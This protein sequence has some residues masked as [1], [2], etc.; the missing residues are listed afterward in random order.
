[1]FL[2]PID[3]NHTKP[4]CHSHTRA[5]MCMPLCLQHVVA[6]VLLLWLFVVSAV[7]NASGL[8]VWLH[9]HPGR[10]RPIPRPSRSE[11]TS[12]NTHTFSL[13]FMQASMQSDCELNTCC[14]NCNNTGR[15]KCTRCRAIAVC[16]AAPDLSGTHPE[17]SYNLTPGSLENEHYCQKN[18]T[19]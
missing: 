10:L 9:V 8:P 18:F 7:C 19:S 12:A 11:C 3:R 15:A 6:G 5:R 2:R 14:L 17:I 1:M 4:L 13:C 16:K